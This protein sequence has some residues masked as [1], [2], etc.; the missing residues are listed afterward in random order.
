M[1][2]LLTRVSAADGW[3]PLPYLA[4]AVERGEPCRVAFVIASG[5][6]TIALGLSFP[7]DGGTARMRAMR[8]ARKPARCT[9]RGAPA[10][11]HR[12]RS[13]AARRRAVRRVVRAAPTPAVVRRRARCAA[14]G[15][16]RRTSSAGASTVV[17][18]RASLSGA[19]ALSGRR[20][21]SSNRARGAGR[22]R[23]T[24]RLRRRDR[25]EPPP[26]I[27]SAL[28]ARARRTARALRRLAGPG[29][30]ARKA[31]AAISAPT[32]TGC[33]TR[34]RAPVGL[35]IGGRAPESIALSIIGE[36]HAALAGRGGRPF[37]ET[38]I[39]SE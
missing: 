21:S 10:R 26:G 3:Q 5:E 11:R 28:P 2:I 14:R 4:A 30:A 27:R 20:P 32:P 16:A 18:H 38:S 7:A 22:G 34:L 39:E 15:R 23:E 35:D 12:C 25:H 36:V 19:R 6:P 17:D 31:A 9:R 37:I 24:R 29:R 8:R 33:A 1:D 13:R